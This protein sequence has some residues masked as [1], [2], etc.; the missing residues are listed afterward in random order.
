MED[1]FKN[2]SGEPVEPLIPV[3]QRVELFFDQ[4]FRSYFVESRVGAQE[5]VIVAPGEHLWMSEL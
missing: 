1:Y 5:S 4:G 3:G 2:E